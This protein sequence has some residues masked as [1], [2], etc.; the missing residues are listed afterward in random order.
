MGLLAG[1]VAGLVNAIVTV[2]FKLP[3]F[4]ATLGMFYIARGLAAWFVAGQ[5]LTGWPEGYNLLGRKLND[6][7]LYFGLSLPPGMMRTVAEVVSVQTI[8]MFFVALLAG[9]VLAYTPFGMKVCATGRQHPRRCLC[10]HQYQ[11][12]ALHCADAGGALRNHGRHHQR[13]LLSQFQSGRR[14]VPRA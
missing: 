3:A 2:G 11:P 13:R 5:Q 14:S 7:F 9:I 1:M 10:R 8:W 6:V 4:I 12:G